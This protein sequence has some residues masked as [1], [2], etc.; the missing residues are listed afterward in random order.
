MYRYG[1]G[2][3]DTESDPRPVTTQTIRPDPPKVSTYWDFDTDD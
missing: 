1:F 2:V 3:G